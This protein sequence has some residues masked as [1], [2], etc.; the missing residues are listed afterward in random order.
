MT[1]ELRDPATEIPPSSGRRVG[2]ADHVGRE[3]DGG[4]ELGDDKRGPHHADAEPKQQKCLVAVRQPN[5]HHRH[6][7]H[8]QQPGVGE[9][10]P[11][12]IAQPAGGEPRENGDRRRRDDCVGDLIGGQPEILAHDRH[13]RC[14]AEPAEKAEEKCRP[15]EVKGSHLGRVDGQQANAGGLVQNVHDQF[16]SSPL[17]LGSAHRPPP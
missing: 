3:H 7:S 2:S 8:D 10:R 6:G 17:R 13:Q 4:M 15:G 11:D 14:D 1:M 9:A 16:L 5:A 12:P